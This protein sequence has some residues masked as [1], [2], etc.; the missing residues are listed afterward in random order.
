M[1]E[2]AR[3]G[4]R[5][6]ELLKLNICRMFLH[7]VMLSDIGTVDG[8]STSLSAWQGQRNASCG[9]EQKWPRV[10]TMLPK[11]C[12]D[13]WR[14]ALRSCFLGRGSSR[15]LRECMGRW[16]RFPKR[17]LWCCSPQED[18]LCKKEGWN[19]RAFPIHWVRA[20]ARHGAAKCRRSDELTR[21]RPIDQ[22]PASVD[23]TKSWV[24][25][26]ATEELFEAQTTEAASN[27]VHSILASR[28][29]GFRWAIAEMDVDDNGGAIAH[30]LIK[31]TAIVVSNGSF[32]NQQG[33]SAII[34]E[35]ASSEGRL[36]GINV[37]PGNP[38]SHSACRSEL[39][40]VAGIVRL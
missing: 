29:E 36:V 40:G 34:I 7:S 12:W 15:T 33:T 32:K 35:G 23:K 30:A 16:H 8:K 28:P 24:L 14:K 18:R 26:V 13:L 20:S 39:G 6:P 27:N 11:E 3:A 22:T 38:T 2:F 1:V 25:K 4:F 19:F 17:W 21:S 31:G 37:I 9:A 10:Q 5:R